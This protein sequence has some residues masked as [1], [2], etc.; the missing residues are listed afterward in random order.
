M[1]ILKSH[2]PLSLKLF[3]NVVIVAMILLVYTLYCAIQHWVRLCAVSTLFCAIQHWVRL[4][5]VCTL[6][7][8]IQHWVRLG[9]VYTLS[10]A[11]KHWVR[12]ELI[13]A[14]YSIQTQHWL[15]SQKLWKVLAMQCSVCL[16]LRLTNTS[17]SR[18][19]QWRHWCTQLKIVVNTS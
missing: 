14:I 4:C 3:S 17:L 12:S 1:K 11:S 8:A 7:C 5:A 9:A 18:A 6:Y 2:R 15:Q 16:R 10:C 19:L 13:N